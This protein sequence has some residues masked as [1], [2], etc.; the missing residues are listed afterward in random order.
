MGLN[1]CVLVG[2]VARD[3]EFKTFD[4]KG[5]DGQDLQLATTGIAINGRTKDNVQFITLNFWNGRSKV[6]EYVKKGD[7]ITVTGSV[8]TRAY[9]AKDG[10]AKAELILDVAQIVLAS[11][12]RKADG[13]HEYK[14]DAASEEEAPF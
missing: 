8:R 2:N 12:S 3:P 4:G 9:E 7:R 10:K 11:N 13:A 1:H 14:C 6:A 5:R